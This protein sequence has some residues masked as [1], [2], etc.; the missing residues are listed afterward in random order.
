MQYIFVVKLEPATHLHFAFKNN[1]TS[2]LL[3]WDACTKGPSR[4]AIR[5]VT[6]CAHSPFDTLPCSKLRASCW[7][8]KCVF[9]LSPII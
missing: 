1:I 5:K 4:P 2:H 8:L 6:V 7:F 9:S 3:S